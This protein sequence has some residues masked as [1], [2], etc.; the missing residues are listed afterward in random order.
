MFWFSVTLQLLRIR[1]IICFGSKGYNFSKL[2]EFFVSRGLKW[3]GT[4][5]MEIF[6]LAVLVLS[7]LAAA[8]VYQADAIAEAVDGET[9]RR[10]SSFGSDRGFDLHWH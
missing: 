7:T 5:L 3:S 1:Y 8:A 4:I 2:F 9:I 6:R 10:F